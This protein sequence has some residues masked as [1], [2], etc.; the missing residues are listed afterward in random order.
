MPAIYSIYQAKA[1]FSEVLRQVREEGKTITVS[2]R[3]QPVAEIRPVRQDPKT[4]EER[5]EELERTGELVRATGPRRPFE[6]GKPS[7]GILA[8]FLSA[9]NE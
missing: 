5:L 7:P 2:Y 8:R 6:L 9:R 1:Q 3:G 4:I